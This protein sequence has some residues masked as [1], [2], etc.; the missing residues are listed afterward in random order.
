MMM[1]HCKASVTESRIQKI[2]TIASPTKKVEL[3]LD[4]QTRTPDFL[5][6]WYFFLEK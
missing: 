6:I 2:S 1:L 3:F 5:A 4:D